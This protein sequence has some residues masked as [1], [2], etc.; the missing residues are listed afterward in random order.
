M[1]DMVNGETKIAVI[2]AHPDDEILG[3]GATLKKWAGEGAQIKVLILGEGITSR[4]KIRNREADKAHIEQLKRSCLHANR[5]LGVDEVI[6]KEF[7]D[8]RFDSVDLLDIIKE[9]ESFLQ[10]FPAT[11]IMTHHRGDL[12]ID[13]QITN[14]AV[15]TA[16][17]P[18]Q[19]WAPDII[20][21]FDILSSTELYFGSRE[22]YFIPHVFIDV[23]RTIDDKI[24][25]MSYYESEIKPFPYARSLDSVRIQAQRYGQMVNLEAA[26]AFECV[27]A[28]IHGS[29]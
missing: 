4:R 11:I 27:R 20:L 17:R 3:C 23:T 26:E 15:M 12:N 5:T 21:C 22:N 9:I 2:A 1:N 13:H 14:R 10:K 16:S 19:V 7:P 25:A 18:G 24:K 29:R 28:V 8:N 6:L